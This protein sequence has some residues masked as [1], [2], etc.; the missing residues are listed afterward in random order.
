M[1]LPRLKPLKGVTMTACG[2]LAVALSSC[3]SSFVFEDLRPCIP[4]YRVRLSYTHN[5]AYE[6]QVSKIEAAEAY[7]FDSDGN[8]AAVSTADRQMLIDND[9]TLPLD[10]ERFKDYDVIVW[11]GLIAESPFNLDGKRAVT[12]KEDLTCRLQTITDEDANDVSSTKFPGLFHGLTSVNYTVE[13]GP[14]ERTVPMIKNTNDIVVLIQKDNGQAVEP[15]YYDVE[16][17]DANGIMNHQNS[18][19]GTDILYRHHTYTAG[20]FQIPDGYGGKEEI[21]APSGKWEFS[22]AR[23]MENSEARIQ[24]RLDES[25]IVLVDEKLIDLLEKVRP[26][27]MPLQEFLDRQDTYYLTYQLRVEEDWIHLSVYVNDWLIIKNDIE[28]D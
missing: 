15:D 17:T 5:M 13:D 6:E 11:G 20:D 27:S 14:E 18:V 28:W 21:T 3:D 16:I 25:N 2:L 1:F 10:I 8:L 26:A 24:I 9:W 22:V 7:A 12:T 4:D 19:S 23:L